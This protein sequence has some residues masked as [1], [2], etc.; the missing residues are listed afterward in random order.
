MLACPAS[1]TP[2]VLRYP[3]LLKKIGISMRFSILLLLVCSATSSFGFVPSARAQV[4][5]VESELCN[6]NQADSTTMSIPRWFQKEISIT[7]PSRGCHLITSEVN[8][9]CPHHI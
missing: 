6:S 7:A 9:V 3:P 1:S 5:K 2:I 4:S 8:K